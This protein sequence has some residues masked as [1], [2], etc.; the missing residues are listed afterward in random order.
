MAIIRRPTT[1]MSTSRITQHPITKGLKLSFPQAN[2]EL[3]GNLRWQPAGQLSTCSRPPRTITPFMQQ[4]GPIRA[5][6][7]H[8]WV[9][10]RSEPMLWT[11]E[12]GK[13]HVFG[14]ALGHDVENVQTPAF[15]T[16]F[17]RGTEWAATGK[18]TLPIPAGMGQ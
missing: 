11:V 15:V 4:V 2:D 6:R 5:R 9:Q 18:V 8:W 10:A 7:S 13:G 3:Y 1:S 12:Y 16:T 17:T 14:T